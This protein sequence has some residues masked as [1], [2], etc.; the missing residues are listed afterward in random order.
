MLICN[1]FVCIGVRLITRC[2]YN[3]FEKQIGSLVGIL[4]F[5]Y[6]AK[7]E[8]DLKP[9]RGSSVVAWTSDN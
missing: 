6:K 9:L 7:Q 4:S 8:W 5:I 3:S 1:V 2:H